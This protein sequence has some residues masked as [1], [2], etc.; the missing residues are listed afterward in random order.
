VPTPASKIA[1]K[2]K[3]IKEGINSQKDK[4]FIRGN[5][6]SATPSISGISQ[7]PKPPIE[8]GITMKKIMTKA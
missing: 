1:L 6:I 3:N 8:I 2:S 4:L 7:L 5:A